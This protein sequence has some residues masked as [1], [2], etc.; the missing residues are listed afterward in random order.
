MVLVA[1]AGQFLARHRRQI[2]SLRENGARGRPVEPRDQIEQRGFARP[3]GAQQRQKLSG[4]HVERNLVHRADQRLAHLVMAGDAVG[5]DRKTV[6]TLL[7]FR[8]HSYYAE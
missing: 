7:E 6:R 8:A 5:A 4:A 2:A 1:M 3:A